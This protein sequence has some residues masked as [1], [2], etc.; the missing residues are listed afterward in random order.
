MND[1]VLEFPGFI[2]VHVHFRDPGVPEAETT[3]SG[4]AAS[5]R[6]GFAAVVT[7]PNTTPAIDTPSAVRGHT[8]E[9]SEQSNN[10]TIL[11]TSACI[12]KGRLGRE[13]ADLEALAEAG[14]AFF[15]DDGS[16]VADDK[17]MEEAMTRIA[18]LNMVACQHAMD[19]AEQR[20]G[21]IRDCPLARKLGLPI[22]SVETE[23]K[24]IRRDLSLVR[25]TGCRLHVQHISTAEGVQLVRDAQREGLPVTAEA[26]PHHLLL[27]CD[28]IPLADPADNS[29]LS[30]ITHRSSLYKMAPPLG[31]R[32]DRA[33]LRKA[34]KDGVL[35]FATDHAPHPAVKKSLGFAAS[36]NGIIG[37]ETAIPITYGVM[38]EEEGMSVEKW[39]E[40][41]WKLPRDIVRVRSAE[42][43]VRSAECGMPSFWEQLRKTRVEVGAE[44]AV[45]VSSFA[46]LSRNC[47][48]HGMKFR[49]WPAT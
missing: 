24:A 46:S 40:A 27:T 32:E 20:G 7:M 45:D 31:N 12:T 48:Y 10:R 25:E 16:Y 49:C 15:T 26:T 47:P 43:G 44:R 33:E 4:L 41:W 35:M 9:Q 17:V 22:I 3:A 2:D 42:C 38:V 11:L 28:D 8:I 23:T 39:A 29:R 34:V 5:A 19:P 14:A 1:R 37:L 6:G 30:L 21:V 36:A 18:A 13:V